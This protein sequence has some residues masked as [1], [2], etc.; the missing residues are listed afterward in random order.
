MHLRSLR[1]LQNLNREHFAVAFLYC[2]FKCFRISR[3]NNVLLLYKLHAAAISFVC[4]PENI[5]QMNSRF[6]NCFILTSPQAKDHSQTSRSNGRWIQW[7]DEE[8]TDRVMFTCSRRN[9]YFSW[10]SSQQEFWF[11][12]LFTTLVDYGNWFA[13]FH[14][15]F[16]NLIIYLP[17]LYYITL[18]LHYNHAYSGINGP[19][20]EAECLVSAEYEMH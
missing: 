20:A 17:Q 18:T 2:W 3:T 14:V 11:S 15:L 12:I 16:S 13:A 1:V 19:R 7:T 8:G 10:R 5:Q 6:G 9:K 4:H